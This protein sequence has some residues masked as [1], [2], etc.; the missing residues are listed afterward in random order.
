M[1]NLT[2]ASSGPIYPQ[3]NA[4]IKI[5]DDV[6]NSTD[7]QNSATTHTKMN[8]NLATWRSVTS[9]IELFWRGEYQYQTF[10]GNISGIPI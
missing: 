2:T 1:K 6:C 3:Y 5:E 9:G 8:E 7:A 10:E 4:Q